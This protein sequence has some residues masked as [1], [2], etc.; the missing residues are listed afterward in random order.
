M[1]HQVFTWIKYR[2][3]P[4]YIQCPHAIQS[5]DTFQFVC[6]IQIPVARVLYERHCKTWRVNSRSNSA[7]RFRLL[8]NSVKMNHCTV[9]QYTTCAGFSS[10]LELFSKQFEGILHA[11]NKF[12]SE[13]AIRSGI[14]SSNRLTG[15]ERTSY[16]QRRHPTRVALTAAKMVQELNVEDAERVDD[17]VGDDV[18]EERA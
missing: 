5:V 18:D 4:H 8:R 13:I 12:T 10:S 6:I 17:A 14:I 7:D 16:N 3:D 9:A 15:D 2:L 1:N 11:S